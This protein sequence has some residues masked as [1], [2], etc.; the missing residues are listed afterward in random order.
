MSG[1]TAWPIISG[2][3]PATL[4]GPK[5]GPCIGPEC[6]AYVKH[7]ERGW[8]MTVPYFPGR[9]AIYPSGQISVPG[10]WEARCAMMPGRSGVYVEEGK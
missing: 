3:C 10:H 2:I 1:P 6:A 7:R 4:A 8:G 9:D 5:Q